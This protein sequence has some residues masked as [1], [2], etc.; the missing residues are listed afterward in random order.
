VYL[1]R[2]GLVRRG[3]YPVSA[4]SAAAVGAAATARTA[5]AHTIDKQA[6]RPRTCAAAAIHGLLH[7]GGLSVRGGELRGHLLAQRPGRQRGGEQVDEAAEEQGGPPHL[8]CPP[9]TE[10]MATFLVYFLLL[11]SNLKKFDHI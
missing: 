1:R 4:N 10:G 3:G 7:L 6:G 11:E 5:S 8:A 2:C 9:T